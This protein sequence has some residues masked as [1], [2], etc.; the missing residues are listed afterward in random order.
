[1]NPAPCRAAEPPPARHSAGRCRGEFADTCAA[2]VI[3]V[4]PLA[5]SAMRTSM[6]QRLG[7]GLSV[8]QFRCLNFIDLHPGSTLG[9]VA[10]FLGV[11]LA[12]ASAMVERL[13]QAGHVAASVSAGD[14]RRSALSS[15]ASGRSVLSSMRAAT[16]SEFAQRLSKHSPQDLAALLRGLQLLKSTFQ[17]E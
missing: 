4:L 13:V 10:G 12:T 16:Q 8:P 2:A 11:T 3:D 17:Q 5:M 14:R 6:R 15:S 9:E 1:M 7:E